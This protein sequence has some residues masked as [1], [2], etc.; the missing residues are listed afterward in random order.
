MALPGGE[1]EAGAVPAED[2]EDEE[3]EEGEEADI[4]LPPVPAEIQTRFLELVQAAFPDKEVEITPLDLLQKLRDIFTQVLEPVPGAPPVSNQTREEIQEMLKEFDT[5]I[6]LMRLLQP[7]ELNIPQE[8]SMD[9]TLD[10]ALKVGQKFT[11]DYDF[12][13]TTYL[14]LKVLG[15]REG[16]AH[17]G[18]KAIQ[19]L[20]RNNPP[21]IPCVE[22]GQPAV[23]CE[24]G[25]YSAWE[26]ALCEK[27]AKKERS[28]WSYEE[29][30]PIVNSPRTGVCG[31][32]G[33]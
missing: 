1:E 10:E 4:E 31:Y 25:Y 23:V 27:C 26:S 2:E 20:A 29:M 5:Q 11:H 3:D 19:V 28:E 21:V 16:V 12:G 9:I 18:S 32:T 30:L 17:K 22:C 14:G 24:P 6:M 8:R 33:D 15:E 13:S 7:R